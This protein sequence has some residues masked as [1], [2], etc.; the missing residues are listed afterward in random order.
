MRKIS[1]FL[2]KIGICK[3]VD[4]VWGCLT[5]L[6]R[7]L[8]VDVDKVIEVS[9][10]KNFNYDQIINDIIPYLPA[11]QQQFLY[12]QLLTELGCVNQDAMLNVLKTYL[13][14]EEY[15]TLN[16]ESAGATYED[17]VAVV[18]SKMIITTVSE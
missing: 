11:E 9:V 17:V 13:S 2:H 3:F 10:I 7:A 14:S 5:V 4:L 1:D 6:L 12:Q 15:T 16:L 8:G 18:A